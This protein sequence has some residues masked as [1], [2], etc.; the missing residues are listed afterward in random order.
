MEKGTMGLTCTTAFHYA[1]ATQVHT[2]EQTSNQVHHENNVRWNLHAPRHIIMLLKVHRAKQLLMSCISA[3]VHYRIG[4]PAKFKLQGACSDAQL[5]Q[6][7]VA[8]IR[9]PGS[10]LSEQMKQCQL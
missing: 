8:T 10:L 4:V 1:T 7:L 9:C 2:T 3:S 5:Q 6:G